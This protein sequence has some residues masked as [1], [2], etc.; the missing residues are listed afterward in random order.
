MKGK[1]VQERYYDLLTREPYKKTPKVK[2]PLKRKETPT[3]TKLRGSQLP[4]I[5]HDKKKKKLP[6]SEGG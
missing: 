1:S 2:D 3:I 5:K 6:E 4:L